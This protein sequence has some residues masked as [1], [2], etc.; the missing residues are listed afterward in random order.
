MARRKTDKE[1]LKCGSCS[2][3]CGGC[4]YFLGFLGAAVYYIQQ[5]TGFWNGVL[6]FLKALVWPAF[7]VYEVLKF[8][9]T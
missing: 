6:G 4:T 1:R 8:L 9:A 7:L 5:A 3:A 2:G